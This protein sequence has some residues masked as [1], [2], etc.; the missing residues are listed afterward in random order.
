MLPPF[1]IL[2]AST[3]MRPASPW[4]ALSR[5]PSSISMVAPGSMSGPATKAASPS[6]MAPRIPSANTVSSMSRVDAIRV[7]TS[8]W[9]LLPNR[10]PFRLIR[11]TW[12]LAVRRPLMTLGSRVWMRLSATADDEGWLNCTPWPAPILKV[13]Q[14]SVALRSIC[15][16]SMSV[17]PLTMR[18]SRAPCQRPP[19]STCGSSACATGPVIRP[20]ATRARIQMASGLSRIMQAAP[21]HPSRFLRPAFRRMTMVVC[22]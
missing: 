5:A 9:A 15:W 12:P 7:L 22:L 13:C 6:W 17:P 21:D 4:L 3:M 20:P 14:S 8:T 18:G 2:G 16:M 11:Y 19:G 1:T 10:M